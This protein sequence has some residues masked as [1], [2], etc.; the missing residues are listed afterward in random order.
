MDH[1][2]HNQR[3]GLGDLDLTR[4]AAEP[5]L[6][7]G[8]L[9]LGPTLPSDLRYMVQAV[10]GVGL[11]TLLTNN[12]AYFTPGIDPGAPVAPPLTTD[13]VNATPVLIEL[14]SPPTSGVYGG[15][16]TY[17]AQLT[18]NGLPVSD[19]AVEFTLQE[20]T[21][22]AR[23]D[24]AGI[25]SATFRLLGLPGNATVQVSY[26][27]SPAYAGAT[28][29][30]TVTVAKQNATLALATPVGAVAS[31]SPYTVT[32]TLTDAAGRAIIDR[33]VLFVFSSGSFMFNRTVA[34]DY[35]GPRQCQ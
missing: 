7:E 31:G 11:V 9:Q 22:T 30:S 34:T 24:S 29:A 13:P 19:A 5:A 35:A 2:C 28:A 8:T 27:G 15:E 32:A 3:R 26:A 17:T 10:N 1:P 20:Q 14:L 18:S 23:T 6:W 16:L 25:A 21:R 12:G 4:S 33:S